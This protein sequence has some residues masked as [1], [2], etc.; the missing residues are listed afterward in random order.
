M[1]QTLVLQ[2]IPLAFP[3]EEREHHREAWR[4]LSVSNSTA[5]APGNLLTRRHLDTLLRYGWKVTIT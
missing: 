1:T 4:V 5:F 3:L 2:Y